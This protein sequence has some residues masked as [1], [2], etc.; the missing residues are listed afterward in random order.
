MIAAIL[1]AQ[2]LSMRFG[3]NRGAVLSA[4]TGLVWYG[5]WVFLACLAGVFTAG[6]DAWTVKAIVEVPVEELFKK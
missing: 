5:F 3:A 6:A 4:I 1:R 2:L